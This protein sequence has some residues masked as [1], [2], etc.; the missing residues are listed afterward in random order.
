MFPEP[1]L[2]S[3]DVV[4]RIVDFAV[5][6]RL[7][8]VVLDDSV[9]YGSS[10]P[11]QLASILLMLLPLPYF[12]VNLQELDLRAENIEIT[13]PSVFEK[14]AHLL[15]FRAVELASTRYDKALHYFL[16]TH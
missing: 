7:P 2:S 15:H 13:I 9:L 5:A 14:V 1:I 4:Q 12:L 11:A 6:K 3:A 16:T 8:R 10:I